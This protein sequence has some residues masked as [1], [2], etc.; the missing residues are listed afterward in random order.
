M[1][2]EKA[3]A[4]NPEFAVATYYGLQILAAML[5][6]CFSTP[7]FSRGRKVKLSARACLSYFIQRKK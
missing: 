1:S 3:S 7:C 6:Y 4:L 2:K 5:A